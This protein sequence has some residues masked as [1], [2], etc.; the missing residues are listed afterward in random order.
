[1]KFETVLPA[2]RKGN[3]IARLSWGEGLWYQLTDNPIA[4][5]VP[6]D[7][8]NVSVFLNGEII[9]QYKAMLVEEE[10]LADDWCIL[11]TN[12]WGF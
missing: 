1:M 9:Q 3:K 5:D 12:T 6:N 10:L 11:V 4:T 8:R 2:L 7:D